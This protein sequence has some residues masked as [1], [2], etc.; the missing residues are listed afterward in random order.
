[1]PRAIPDWDTEYG[2]L[3]GKRMTTTPDEVGWAI[4]MSRRGEGLKN[5][6]AFSVYLAASIWFF[7]LPLLGHFGHRFIGGRRGARIASP[8]LADN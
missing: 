8:G 6:A 7:G 5:P 2:C 1:M 4:W 3:F